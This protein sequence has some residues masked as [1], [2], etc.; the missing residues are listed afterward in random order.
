MQGATL[1]PSPL[2]GATIVVVPGSV[3]VSRARKVRR[4]ST[5][6][7][8]RLGLLTGY[9]APLGMGPRLRV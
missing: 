8:A 7:K 6:P 9:R 1:E 4:F 3:N 5:A 2:Q